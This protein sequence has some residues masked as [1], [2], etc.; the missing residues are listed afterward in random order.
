MPIDLLR[1]D[2]VVAA[3]FDHIVTCPLLASDASVASVFT[4]DVQV[5]P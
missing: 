4:M 2:P 1:G 5:G 3:M